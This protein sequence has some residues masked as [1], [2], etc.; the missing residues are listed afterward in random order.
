MEVDAPRTVV[1][2]VKATV[3]VAHVRWIRESVY[4]VVVAIHI[5]EI[6]AI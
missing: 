1:P 5:R 4:L 2:C 6:T 3:Q